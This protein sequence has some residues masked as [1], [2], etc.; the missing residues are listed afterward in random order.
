MKRPKKVRLMIVGWGNREVDYCGGVSH[1]VNIVLGNGRLC[2]FDFRAYGKDWLE[3]D[4]IPMTLD[5]IVFPPRR[6]PKP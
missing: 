6:K 5:N 3:M 1:R 2:S 4:P